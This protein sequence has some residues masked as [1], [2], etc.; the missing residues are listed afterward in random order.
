[1]EVLERFLK[2]CG[3]SKKSILDEDA[4]DRDELV[5]TLGLPMSEPSVSPEPIS[6]KQINKGFTLTP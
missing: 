3:L 1:L 6:F 2:Y 5:A 4:D